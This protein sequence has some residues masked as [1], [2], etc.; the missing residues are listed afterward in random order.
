MKIVYATY[1]CFGKDVAGIKEVK[2]RRNRNFELELVWHYWSIVG[3][4]KGMLDE[5]YTCG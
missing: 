3:R 2:Q 4:E 1:D 5:R